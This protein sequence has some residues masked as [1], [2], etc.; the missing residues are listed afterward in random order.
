MVDGRVIGIDVSTWQGNINWDKVKKDG[1]DFAIIRCGY[2]QTG[3]DD[4]F[5]RNMKEARR[6]GIKVGVYLYSYAHGAYE[7]QLEAKH[8]LDLVRPYGKLDMPIYFDEEESYQYDIAAQLA[9]AF[10]NE[11]E[12]AGYWAG[13]YSSSSKWQSSNLKGLNRYTK[14]VANWG[15][16]SRP[17][18]NAGRPNVSGCDLHQYSSVGE[19]SGISGNVD[20][21]ELYRT[22]LFDDIAGTESDAPAPTP[23]KSNAEIAKEVWEGKW[24]NGDERKKRLTEAGYDYDAIQDIVNDTAPSEEKDG[25]YGVYVVQKG[26]TLTAIAKKYGTTVKKL[27]D[28]N[29]IKNANLIYVGQVIKIV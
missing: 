21:N 6:V 12:K 19:V 23:K 18:H 20:M 11:I 25:E 24:G 13:I 8:C 27:K 17:A 10:C 22:S 9:T 2:G 5:A 4:Q 29:N 26:D 28:G 3:V 16:N 15:S 14:W 7:A 1:I